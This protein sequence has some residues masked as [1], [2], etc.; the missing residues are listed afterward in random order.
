MRRVLLQ[1]GP[2][3]LYTY[4]LF[5]AVAFLLST[6]LILKDAKRAGFPQGKFFDCLIA[7]FLGGLIGGRLLFVAINWRV[8]IQDP[9]RILLFAEGGLAFQGALVLAV[10][11]GVLAAKRSQIPFWKGADLIAPYI[12]LGQAIGRIGC[13]FNGCCYGRVVERGIGVVFPSQDVTRI[14]I[15]L[16]TSLALFSVFAVLLKAREK[17]HFDGYVFSLYLIIYSAV[18]IVLDLFRAD[19]PDVFLFFKL[20]QVISFG[21]FICGL[22]MYLFLKKKDIKGAV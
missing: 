8:Y 15:Q 20:S 6:A 3:T 16:Y 18:R 11:S 17:K 12:A 22:V 21:T 13:F 2:V 19:N 10:L 1:I 9:V 14:P 7:I 5:V 4:G